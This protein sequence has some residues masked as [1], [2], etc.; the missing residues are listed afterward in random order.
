MILRTLGALAVLGSALAN[1]TYGADDDLKA[2]VLRTPT[3]L[4]SEEVAREKLKTYGFTTIEPLQKTGESFTTSVTRDNQPVEV[5]LHRAT[6]MLRNKVS[7]ELIQPSAS[8]HI[9][10][11]RQIPL[12]RREIIRPELLPEQPT[13]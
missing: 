11:D 3:A 8:Q 13:P 6:G 12:D 9:I 4:M 1:P 2:G 7:R 10:Q 5:E